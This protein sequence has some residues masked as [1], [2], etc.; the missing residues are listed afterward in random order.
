M[1][2]VITEMKSHTYESHKTATYYTQ[3]PLNSVA[4]GFRH[5]P[6]NPAITTCCGQLDLMAGEPHAHITAP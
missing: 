3:I 5:I 2:A 6:L 4:S 1:N